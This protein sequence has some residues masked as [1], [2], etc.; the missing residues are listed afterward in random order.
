MKNHEPDAKVIPFLNPGFTDG[1][2]FARLGLTWYGFTPLI[3]RERAFNVMELVHAPNE[4]VSIE[5]VEGGSEV[6]YDLI[7]TW[8]M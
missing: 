3:I 5:A 8:S 1:K 2:W 7:S 6:L 4:R